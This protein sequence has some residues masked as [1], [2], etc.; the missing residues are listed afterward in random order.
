MAEAGDV[1]RD[2]QINPKVAAR[3]PLHHS[4]ITL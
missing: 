3:F 1:K 2:A 4:N